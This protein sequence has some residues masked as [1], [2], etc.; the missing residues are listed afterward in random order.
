MKPALVIKTVFGEKAEV[1]ENRFP[2]HR[3]VVCC[4]LSVV[5]ERWSH[6]GTRVLGLQAYATKPSSHS[7]EV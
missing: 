2:C 1:L 6:T 7:A 4:V 5:G 3:T